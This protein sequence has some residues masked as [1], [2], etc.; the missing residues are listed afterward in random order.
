[1]T[2]ASF[3]SILLSF[4]YLFIWRYKTRSPGRMVFGGVVDRVFGFALMVC[5]V[6]F[7]DL[8]LLFPVEPRTS[9]RVLLSW[10]MS[11]LEYHLT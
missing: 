8:H 11:M 10:N 4:L 5:L 6:V 7:F 9:I 3:H 2:E 1:M